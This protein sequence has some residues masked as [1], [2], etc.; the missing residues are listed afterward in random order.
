MEYQFILLRHGESHWNK[1][2]RFT[3]W[4]DIQLTSHGIEE[5]KK[6]AQL[7]QK[8][9]LAFDLAMTSVLSRAI[10]T[11]WIV[12]SEMDLMYIPVMKDW[13]LNERHYGNLQGLNK[14]ET[15]E[16][17]GKEIVHFW[18]RS[19]A[20]CPPALTLDDPRHPRFDPRYEHINP[21]LLP[22]SESLQD[23]LRRVRIWYCDQ[24]LPM[25]LDRK[26]ILIVAHGN[27]LRA[28]VMHLDDISGNAIP[29]L[30]IPTGVPLIYH[31]NENLE[32][33]R[34]YYLE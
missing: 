5:A 4:T 10:H 24:L 31:L 12:L 7:L 25:L 22:A 13:R 6:A 15:A 8:H 11:L 28:L 27:S 26:R 34:R 17:L 3:G 30:Y 18:R 19:Y 33:T 32:I 23:T 20:G 1:E 14:A 16:R 9:G 2:N 29:E 21:E